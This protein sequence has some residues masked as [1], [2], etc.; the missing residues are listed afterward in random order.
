MLSSLIMLQG[1]F[2][3]GYPGHE[4]IVDNFMIMVDAPPNSVYYNF[5]FEIAE[6]LTEIYSSA[7]FD[8]VNNGNMF[9]VVF[10]Q[11]PFEGFLTVIRFLSLCHAPHFLSWV[12]REI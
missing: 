7:T 4:E 6:N 3:G 1:A 12:S 9:S 2:F 5:L 10:C 11:L 8:F